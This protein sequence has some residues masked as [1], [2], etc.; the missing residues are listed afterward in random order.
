MESNPDVE[1]SEYH[2]RI[3]LK[4]ENLFFVCNTSIVDVLAC[5]WSRFCPLFV[6]AISKSKPNDSVSWKDAF[7]ILIAW[8][9]QK[10]TRRKKKLRFFHQRFQISKTLIVLFPCNPVYCYSPQKDVTQLEEYERIVMPLTSSLI[11]I[12]LGGKAAK[13]YDKTAFFDW[14]M[15]TKE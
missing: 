15:N 1:G 2:T 5:L 11:L 7:I 10:G 14:A 12:M 9:F 4:A 13:G 3:V 8:N 6:A